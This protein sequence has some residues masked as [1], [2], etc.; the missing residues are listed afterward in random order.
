VQAGFVLV[1]TGSGL[2]GWI[3]AAN[4]GAGPID[5]NLLLGPPA[6][7]LTYS[8]QAIS[9]IHNKL[10]KFPTV[11]GKVG[12]FVA[13]EIAGFGGFGQVDENGKVSASYLVPATPTLTNNVQLTGSGPLVFVGEGAGVLY[14]PDLTNYGKPAAVGGYLGFSVPGTKTEGAIGVY[15]ENPSIA[16]AYSCPP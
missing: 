10:S 8:Q 12:G 5:W 14:E 7:T 9:A 4:G 15:I 2:N 1:Q 13:G 11:C 16:G 6:P 3:L